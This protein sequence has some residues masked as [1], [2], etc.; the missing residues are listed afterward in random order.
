MQI[1]VA[2]RGRLAGDLLVAASFTGESPRTDGLPEAAADRLSEIAAGFDGKADRQRHGDATAAGLGSLIVYGLGSRDTWEWAD[3]QSWIGR[4][5]ADARRL[6]ARKVVLVPPAHDRLAGESGAEQLARTLALASYRYREFKA[7][8][9]N[10]GPDRTTLVPTPEEAKSWRRGVARGLA[11]AD[12]TA[13]ARDLANTP[14]NVATPEWI[15]AQARALAAEHEMKLRV[16][17]PKQLERQR[18]GAILAVAAGSH[19]PPRLAR[20]EWGS[21]GPTIALVGKGVTFDTGGISIKPSAR[22]DEMKWDKC[23]ACTVLGV[24]RAAAALDLPVRLRAY[25]PL[26][27]NMPDGA[28]YRPGDIV[29]CRNGK[30]VEILN[31]DAEGRMI[32]AD[33]LAWA[34]D[35]RPDALLEY[36]TL[37]GAAVV[38]LGQGG[39]ALYS[40][41]DGLAGE[42]TDAAET[43]GERLWRMPLWR[44]FREQM[45]GD[46][47]DLKNAGGRWG[48]ANTA[49]AFLSCFVDGV[50]RWAHWD[51]AGPA[52]VGSNGKGPRGATGY[53][54]A[55]TIEWLR[56]QTGGRRS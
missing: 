25:L 11:V 56:R 20:L 12:A 48:G 50:E 23:G 30:T 35:E 32:L 19:N 14:A 52:Y 16:L 22:M 45:K 47:A 4:V 6:D 33:A 21:R 27:E 28:A 3:M 38:A 43:A 37:T 5:L 24:M 1:T 2:R 29:R 36:S 15:A 40:P 7:Q 8:D 44:E 34:C 18:M 55:S 46:H 51:I 53:G 9:D 13:W 41:D 31:T 10:G 49:A 42:L 17:G 26:V 39:A 54:V